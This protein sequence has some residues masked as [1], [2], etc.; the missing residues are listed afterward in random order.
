MLDYIAAQPLL[1]QGLNE[2]S[3][4]GSRAL[5]VQQTSCGRFQGN[6]EKLVKISK[7][8]RYALGIASPNSGSFLSL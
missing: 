2:I 3:Y 7:L 6:I 1:R 5:I 8:D 4:Q